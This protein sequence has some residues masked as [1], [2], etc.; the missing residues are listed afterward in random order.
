M[1]EGVG[2]L[3]HHLHGRPGQGADGFLHV[4]DRDLPCDGGGSPFLF[5]Q[6]AP[7]PEMPFDA[8]MAIPGCPPRPRRTTR[9]E[10]QEA[11]R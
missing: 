3:L 8:R 4:A 7:L 6:R 11:A 10:A 1:P 2:R 5:G 9:E